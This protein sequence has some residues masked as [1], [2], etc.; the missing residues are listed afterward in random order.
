LQY[1]KDKYHFILVGSDMDKKKIIYYA[2]INQR[3]IKIKL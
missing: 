3:P 1:D 2:N